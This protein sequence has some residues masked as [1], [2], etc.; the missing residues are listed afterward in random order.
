MKVTLRSY[1]MK[2]EFKKGNLVKTHVRGWSRQSL[3]IVVNTHVTLHAYEAIDVYLFPEQ[4][5]L[6]FYPDELILRGRKHDG[7]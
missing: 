2:S 3:G 6:R 1:K 4:E 5:V 7:R